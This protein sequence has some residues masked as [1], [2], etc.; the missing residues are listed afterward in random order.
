MKKIFPLILLFISIVLHGQT[1]YL[2]N[3]GNEISKSDFRKLKKNKRLSFTA[4]D[5][6]GDRIKIIFDRKEKGEVK[7]Y[8]ELIQTLE[9]S[10]QVKLD[11]SMPI[12]I[13]YYPGPDVCNTTGISTPI[14]RKQWYDEMEKGAPS[15]PKS[16]FLYVYKNDDKLKN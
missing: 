1:T 2:D 6:S 9:K 7:N 13:I 8:T 16:N 3:K 10:L 4:E 14:E 12:V 11:T 15:V 5:E